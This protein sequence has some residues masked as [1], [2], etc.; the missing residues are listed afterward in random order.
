M[1]IKTIAILIVGIAVLIFLVL[2]VFYMKSR[3][4]DE[5]I[6]DD[7]EGADF[8]NYCAD[9]LAAEGFENVE[10]TPPS[11]DYGVDIIAD[12][13]GVT[14]AIQCKCY[15]DS[16]GVRAV[17][18]AYAGKDFY[19][20]MVAAVMSN[21]GFTK[22]AITLAEKLNV[23]LWNGD[24]VMGLIHDVTIQE[25][26]SARNAR[27]AKAAKSAGTVKSARTAKPSP[28]RSRKKTVRIDTEDEYDYSETSSDADQY[29]GQRIQ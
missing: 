25:E 10:T 5:Q 11:H 24:Y 2:W 3:D 16:V 21:Q 22:N 4:R 8:E 14:Y 29:L 15:S 7:M 13:D 23:I 6:F 26:R 9:L 19:G 12:K 18:E 28:T 17:Q 20:C 27:P 1:D